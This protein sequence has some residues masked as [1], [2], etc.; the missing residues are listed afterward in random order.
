M[1]YLPRKKALIQQYF[2]RM[3][4]NLYIPNEIV[5]IIAQ[6]VS[7]NMKLFV[8]NL[9]ICLKY[10]IIKST[11]LND[12]K[13]CHKQTIEFK[14]M[15]GSDR[16]FNQSVVAFDNLNSGILSFTCSQPLGMVVLCLC[17]TFYKRL[18]FLQRKC[19]FFFCNTFCFVSFV[20]D[21]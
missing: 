12:T 8:F 18:F 17:V 9:K 21:S 13:L 6:Y 1:S 4:T 20:L 5:T 2:E 11:Y 3:K 19:D 10:E 7:N 16:G 14:N 15:F